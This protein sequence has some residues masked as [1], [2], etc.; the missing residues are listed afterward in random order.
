MFRK[1]I[2]DFLR[3]ITSRK[4]DQPGTELFDHDLL[5][6]LLLGALQFGCA[7][8]FLIVLQADHLFAD[9]ADFVGSLCFRDLC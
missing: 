9:I 2:F 4:A 8:L 3:E 6:A 1:G 7:G 5:L